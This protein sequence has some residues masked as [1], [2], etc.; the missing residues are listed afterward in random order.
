METITVALI[1]N[2]NVGKTTLFNS[3]TGGDQH[4]GNW[5]GVTVE[6]VEGKRKV[7]DMEL[8][9]VDL[10]GT[11]S[12]TARSPDEKIARDFLLD[13]SLDIILQVV[14][15]SRIE[16]NLY[17]TTQLLEYG[18]PV[19]LALNKSDILEAEGRSLN[20]EKMSTFLGADCVEIVASENRGISPLVDQLI[21]SRNQ[22]HSHPHAIGFGSKIDVKIGDLIEILE[23]RG[24]VPNHLPLHWVGTRLLE[25]DEQIRTMVSEMDCGEE[26]GQ[27]IDAI[28]SEMME[29]EM[30]D[31][32]H[33]TVSTIVS[34]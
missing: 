10:P 32:R 22:S 4:V 20:I 7:G 16:R 26:I 27:I 9:F 11:Y 15:A 3:L 12:I 2:P 33:A 13:P 5:P 29:I 24:S 23:S 17:L 18:K 30:A 31:S 25:A 6:K 28:D 34:H 14:D 19:V 8:T 21:E 1:G